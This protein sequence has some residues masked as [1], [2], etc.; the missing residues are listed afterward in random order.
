VTARSPR[1]RA[2]SG[3]RSRSLIPAASRRARFACAAIQDA[4]YRIS[5]KALESSTSRPVHTLSE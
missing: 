3:L 2:L 4:P 5:C 1:A